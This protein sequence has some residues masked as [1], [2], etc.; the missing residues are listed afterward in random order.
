MTCPDCGKPL[1]GC[2][3]ETDNP[4]PGRKTVKY[5]GDLCA[6]CYEKRI[7]SRYPVVNGSPA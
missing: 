3:C 4:R 7:K 2:T 6:R 5:Q 1:D